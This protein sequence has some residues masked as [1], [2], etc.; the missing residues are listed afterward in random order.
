M[1]Q[2]NLLRVFLWMMWKL[3]HYWSALQFLTFILLFL[4][5]GIVR[6][7]I[8]CCRV[9]VLHWCSGG[10]PAIRAALRLG[11][12]EG[13]SDRWGITVCPRRNFTDFLILLMVS[14]HA[15]FHVYVVKSVVTL[16]KNSVQPVLNLLFQD[17]LPSQDN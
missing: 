7:C 12:E 6:Q 17:A 5:S 9:S 16:A 11:R 13:H 3:V 2:I 8:G 15:A 14:I 10:C 4:L 1:L